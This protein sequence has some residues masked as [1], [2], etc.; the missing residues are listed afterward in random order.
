MELI[1]FLGLIFA[2]FLY[3]MIRGSVEAKQAKIK[4]RNRLREEYTERFLDNELS[5]EELALIKKRFLYRHAEEIIIDDIT[6]NDLDMDDVFCQMNRTCSAVGAEALYD[7]LR[8]PK[9]RKDDFEGFEE[10]VNYLMGQ[11]EERLNLQM[12]L[13]NLRRKGRYSLYDYIDY[14]ERL[15]K[16]SNMVHILQLALFIASV[17][18]IFVNSSL[19]VMAL[20]AMACVNITTYL[21]HKGKVAPYVSTFSYIMKM[22]DCADEILAQ[23]LTG[24]SEYREK[25]KKNREAFRDFKKGSSMVFKMNDAG[26]GDP[27]E[28]IFDYVKMMTHIDLIQFNKML[29]KTLECKKEIIELAECIGYL[30]AMIAIGSFR[31]S[32]PYYAIPQLQESKMTEIGIEEG[33]HPMLR[34]PVANS[35]KQ[36]RGVVIT[37]S[38]ASGKS[39]FLKMVA[40]NAILAQT[41]HTCTAKCYEAS[42]FRI[43]SSMS[44]RDN[45]DSGES[46][47]MVEIKALK[48]IMDAASKEGNPV[49][50]FVDEVLRGT[51]TVERIAASTQILIKLYTSGV[52]CFAATHDIELT[53]LLEKEY[54]NYHF[55]EEVRDGDVLFSYCL[56]TGRAQTRNAIRLLQIIGFSEDIIKE[57]EDLASS[58][59][60]TSIWSRKEAR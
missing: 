12:V 17:G 56:H 39:T 51:N 26:A 22:L 6:W 53:Y 14:L 38:N 10:D 19:G 3:V 20:I 5:E 15:G 49:L 52:C 8:R 2:V 24:M 54:D 32:L 33:Y 13:S 44:L 36:K 59:M 9:Q 43:L 60:K 41:V 29:N 47:Y 25:L 21:G 48:R 27:G 7:M 42:M 50:C 11:E 30:D 45:L 31:A 18:L 37:G 46:Y 16:R 35:F 57:A 40:I 58:F 23:P 34:E 55:E 1:V 4:L 28:I